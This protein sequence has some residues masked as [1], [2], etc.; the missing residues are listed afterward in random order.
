ML[1]SDKRIYREHRVVVRCTRADARQ[2]PMHRKQLRRYVTRFRRHGKSF[3][4]VLN[5][6]THIYKNSNFS[7]FQRALFVYLFKLGLQIERCLLSLELNAKIIYIYFT[8]YCINVICSFCTSYTTLSLNL[9]LNSKFL[10]VN[11]FK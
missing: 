4:L 10:D 8:T 2:P 3:A 11:S 1:P 6:P 5:S 9:N 7:A